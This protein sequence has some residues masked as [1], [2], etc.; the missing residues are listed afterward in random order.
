MISRYPKCGCSYIPM[1]FFTDLE[2]SA[3]KILHFGVVGTIR[4]GTNRPV[5]PEKKSLMSLL[6]TIK[7]NLGK[8]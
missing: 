3:S 4:V 1:I 6:N 5:K 2:I 8:L 7:Y